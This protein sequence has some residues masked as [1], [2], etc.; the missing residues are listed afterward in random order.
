MMKSPI[1]TRLHQTSNQAKGMEKFVILLPKL[2]LLFQVTGSIGREMHTLKN[3]K[4][5]S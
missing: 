2:I 4:Q 1:K 5:N 3:K